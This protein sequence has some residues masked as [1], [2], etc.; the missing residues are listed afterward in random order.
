VTDVLTDLPPQLAAL[1]V[2]GAIA[3]GIFAHAPLLFSGFVA[4]RR[5]SIMKRRVLFIGTVMMVT[6][7]FLF[8]VVAAVGVPVGAFVI[9][10]VPALISL[11]HI[12]TGSLLLSTVDAIAQWWWVA[13]P[14]ALVLASFL[15]TRYLSRRWNKIAETLDG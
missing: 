15:V 13:L 3:Y 9:F 11:G 4:L 5:R 12:E 8:L 14:P 1:W 2:A 10:F 6:Y 7:G